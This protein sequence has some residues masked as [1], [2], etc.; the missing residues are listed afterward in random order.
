MR[1]TPI[2]RGT[3]LAF[4]ACYLLAV[5][6]A[7]QCS[8]PVTAVTNQTYSS[9]TTQLAGNNSLSLTGV[10]VNGTVQVTAVAGNCVQMQPASEFHSESGAASF[11]SW[12]EA[13]PS[14]VSVSQSSGAGSSLTQSL[15]FT[16]SSPQGASDLYG[17]LAVIGQ[18]VAPNNTRYFAYFMG[19]HSLYLADNSATG[20]RPSAMAHR[21]RPATRS[22]RYEN[23]F[24]KSGEAG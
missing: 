20:R 3:A 15:Q 21:R 6:L 4:G 8:S 19:A 22:A 17:F 2:L 7:A 5:T 14:A 24:S 9:G 10:T 18:Q 12:I 16:F 13:T 23:G 11:S 1:R